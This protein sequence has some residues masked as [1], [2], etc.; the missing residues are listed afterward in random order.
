MDSSTYQNQANTKVGMAESIFSQIR[1]EQM[2]FMFNW[3]SIVPG[4]TFNQYWTIKR[5]HLYLNSRFEDDTQYLGRDKL[6]FNITIPPCEVAMRMLNID[7]KN[8]RLWPLNPESEFSTYLLEK[9]LKVWLKSNKFGKILNQLAEEAP[10]FGS[11][12]LEK[13]TDGAEVV[14]LRRLILDPT[15]DH[16]KE[17][18]FVTTIH[19]MTDQQLRST[20]WD[21]DK[22]ELAISRYENANTSEPY[23]DQYV[24][25]NIMRSTP[26]IKIFKRYGE[27]PQHW[28]DD[29]LDP[30]SKEGKKLIKSL[31]IVAGADWTMKNDDG[32]PV[33]DQGVV[34]FKSKWSKEWPFKDFHY[35]K[36]KGR[37]LGIGVAEMLFPV[38]E[39]VNEMKNQKRV[40]MEI[41]SM[42]LFQTK[43]KSIVRNVLTDLQSGDLMLVGQQGGIEQIPNEERGLESF[44]DEEASYDA[45][46]DKLSFAYEAVRG[47]TSDSNN[48]TL[49]Q[50]QI[51]VA[52]GT[53]VF[54]FKKQNLSLFIQ[55]FF[56]DLV[57]DELLSDLTPEHIMRFAGT[58][59]E[60]QKLDQ[61]A[62]E[63]Y[64]NDYFKG[65]VLAGRLVLENDHDEAKQ[66]A[67]K[68][69]QKMG[70]NRFLKIKGAFY[71]DAEFEFDFLVTDEQDDPSKL[72]QNIQGLITEIAGIP[73]QQDPV[74]KLLVH[75][76]A[77]QMGISRAELE[78][79]EQEQQEIQQQNQQNQQNQQQMQ[80]PQAV[81]PQQPG[82]TAPTAQPV[83]QI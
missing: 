37:W 2:D 71:K 49:G 39:R 65:E 12:V 16:V 45:Q 6:F 15:V 47:D 80:Q 33:S 74:L 32:K 73:W 81:K 76:Q 41:S 53:S 56:N 42:Q 5:I 18:R 38:Q 62:A 27:V 52:Q 40:A 82:R 67:I 68:T 30:E 46:A 75:K 17:S 13:T 43:D 4:Y 36:T 3:I 7:T 26:Y 11:V 24:N 25:V 69:Y 44:K 54:A 55:E 77:E 66:K 70:A 50:T 59:Q 10:R 8:I 61:A 21:Q 23:E 28:L 78:L 63:V 14:D 83:A 72:M 29:G 48:T 9:E 58:S 35:M 20:K 57:L 79:A 31:F 19:Y 34:L 64:A 60:L 22:V 1:K 51:A